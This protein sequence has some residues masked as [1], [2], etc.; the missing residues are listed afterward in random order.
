M[1]RKELKNRSRHP[2]S[3][4]QSISDRGAVCSTSHRLPWRMQYVYLTSSGQSIPMF[5]LHQRN[6]SFNAAAHWT[7]ACSGHQM[8]FPGPWLVDCSFHQPSKE[9]LVQGKPVEDLGAQ[10]LCQQTLLK[11]YDLSPSSTAGKA[12][13]QARP[14]SSERLR[15][16]GLWDFPDRRSNLHQS[17]GAWLSTVSVELL[18]RA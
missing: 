5:T 9:M 6:S 12:N 11:G 17:S 1:P 2:V 8:L 18:N 4:V 15:G 13:S 10:G 7:P 14:T 16:Q 3:P